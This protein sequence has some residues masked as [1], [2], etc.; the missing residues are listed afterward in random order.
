MDTPRI[1]VVRDGQAVPFFAGPSL[2]PPSPSPTLLVETQH[3]TPDDWVSQ[4]VPSHLLTLFLE[5]GALLHSAQGGPVTRF[6]FAADAVAVCTP[7]RDEAIRWT[8][9][10]HVL[11]ICLEQALVQQAARD[12][13]PD[14]RFELPPG[15]SGPNPP[16][17]AMLRALYLEQA[18]GYPA[19]R[20]FV[21]GVGQAIAA[22]LVG[23]MNS[24]ARKPAALVGQL[25]PHCLKRVVEYIHDNLDTE[26]SLAALARCAGL[27]EGHFSR[28]F[29]SSFRASPHQFVT[30]TRI[31]RAKALLA[32]ER[33]SIIDI[34]LMCGFPNPQHF[35]R[36]FRRLT[37]MPPS[38][39]R[40]QSL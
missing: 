9:S 33:H 22:L 34:G 8:A 37:G 7:Q 13:S 40:R 28:L 17:A 16:L 35:S 6:A 3:I 32:K 30:Q 1:C 4:R 5:P 18:S 27:S 31:A 11:S 14:G 36:I 24:L 26:L 19:G 20:L 12:L 38:L 15:A 10:S 39:F 29:R 25:T 2:A 21:D 23:R